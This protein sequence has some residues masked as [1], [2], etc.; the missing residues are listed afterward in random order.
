MVVIGR[1]VPR[2]ASRRIN[3]Q[4][5]KPSTVTLVAHARRGLISANPRYAVPSAR[6]LMRQDTAPQLA[7]PFDGTRAHAVYTCQQSQFLEDWQHH[8]VNR[9]AHPLFP[10][11]LSSYIVAKKEASGGQGVE[12]NRTGQGLWYLRRRMLTPL[13]DGLGRATWSL[14]MPVTRSRTPSF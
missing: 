10:V 2:L 8:Q 12:N 9:I 14:T 6:A 11:A 1:P 4:T 7:I 13:I 3:R 5:D